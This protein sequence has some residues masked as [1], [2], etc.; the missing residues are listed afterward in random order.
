M[1]DATKTKGPRP[2]SRALALPP[3]SRRSRMGGMQRGGLCPLPRRAST[4]AVSH[5]GTP[6]LV[7]G[8]VA[9]AFTFNLLRVARGSVL[10]AEPTSR[11]RGKL[12]LVGRGAGDGLLPGQQ[13]P[14][15]GQGHHLLHRAGEGL[16]GHSRRGD[17]HRR[18]S[19]RVRGA[20]VGGG[21]RLPRCH[22]GPQQRAEGRQH[23]GHVRGRAGAPPPA[24]WARLC[25]PRR[26]T[27]LPRGAGRADGHGLRL[28][29][30]LLLLPHARVLLVRVAEHLVQR[31]ERLGASGNGAKHRA[32]V[33]P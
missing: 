16:H 32:G 14:R 12:H 31:P 15:Q 4:P 22:H 5:R 26:R 27:G 7:H 25:L 28:S 13:V 11:A 33:R 18:R 23:L 24:P 30:L 17:S 21:A 8:H 9:A 29:R 10:D 19:A 3:L 20:R 6:A 2:K 1:P